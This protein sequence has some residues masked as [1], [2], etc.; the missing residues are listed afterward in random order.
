MCIRDS[1]SAVTLVH[2][3]RDMQVAIP[4]HGSDKIN[5]AFA[6]GGAPLLVSTVQDL[7]GV[8][9]DHVAITGFEGFKAMTEALGGV[10]VEVEESSPCLLYTSRCV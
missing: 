6:L 10:D 8:H 9:I 3:P 7:L 2:L 4:G 1:R 5:A